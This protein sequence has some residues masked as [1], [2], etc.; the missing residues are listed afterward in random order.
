MSTEKRNTTDRRSTPTKPF[1][2][3]SLRGRRMR[4]RRAEE[5]KNFFVD[6]YGLHYFIM[7]VMILMLCILDAYFTLKIIR[8]GGNEVNPLM[9][10]AI[11]HTPGITMII[12]YLMTAG[13][14][15]IILV[16]KNFMFFG[17]IRTAYFI[18]VV[19]L[20]Y[21]ILVSYEA[22]FVFTKIPT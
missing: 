9:A 22:Y 13:G 7:I 5:S 1:S 19:F 6:R 21:V 20:I 4:A 18:Y 8:Y 17:K 15:I 12:K 14:I 2:R 16:Y 3:Y 10:V 11:D